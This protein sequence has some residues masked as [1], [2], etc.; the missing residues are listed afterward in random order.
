MKV[1]DINLNK[2]YTSIIYKYVQFYFLRHFLYWRLNKLIILSI[3]LSSCNPI[4]G[5]GTMLHAISTGNT[6]GQVV[7]VTDIVI[8]NKTGKDITTHLMDTI[9][10]LFENQQYLSSKNKEK[11]MGS[12]FIQIDEHIKSLRNYIKSNYQ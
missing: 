10:S 2:T 9:N 8:E 5:A 12:N 7:G 6:A 11:T 4:I 3:V 1:T